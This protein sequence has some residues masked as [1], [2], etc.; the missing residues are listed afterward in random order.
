MYDDYDWYTLTVKS[1]SPQYAFPAAYGLKSSIFSVA[2]PGLVFV[3]YPEAVSKFPWAPVW[4]VLFFAM[5][6]SIGIGS[7]VIEPYL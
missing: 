1:E 3:V 5:L 2:G 4:A 7:Q 6:L